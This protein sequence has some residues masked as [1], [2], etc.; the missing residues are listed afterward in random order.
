MARITQ[1]AEGTLFVSEDKTHGLHRI[2]RHREGLH[3]KPVHLEGCSGFEN[4]P[5]GRIDAAIPHQASGGRRRINRHGQRLHQHPQP[6]DVIS[7][8]VGQ[9]H[10]AQRGRIDSAGLHPVHQ[11]LCGESGIDKQAAAA[12]LDDRRISSTAAAQHDESHVPTEVP[13]PAHR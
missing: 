13:A 5:R 2:V 9:H 3:G 4:L 8:L 10:P 11:L 12:G 1:E 6:A 7:V